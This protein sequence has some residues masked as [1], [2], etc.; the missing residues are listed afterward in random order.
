M[1]APLIFI[2]LLVL[3]VGYILYIMFKPYYTT[4]Q[5]DLDMLKLQLELYKTFYSEDAL[6]EEGVKIKEKFEQTGKYELVK[7][8]KFSEKIIAKHEEEKKNEKSK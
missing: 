5:S 4:R 1:I 3:F 8:T 6:Y 7:L 2:I